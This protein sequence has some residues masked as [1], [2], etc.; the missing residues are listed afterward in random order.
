[1]ATN[2]PNTTEKLYK[3]YQQFLVITTDSRQISLRS[4]FFALK[5]ENFDGNRFAAQALEEGAAI[6]VVDDP[7]IVK[8]RRYILVDDVLQSLQQ[9]ASHHRQQ[10]NIPV[11]GITGSNGKTTTKELVHAV[12]STQYRTV[13][14]SGN[15]NNHIGVPLTLLSINLETEIAVIE[16]GANHP[17]EIAFLCEM[18]RPTHGLITNIGKAHLEGFGGFEGVVRAKTELFEFLKTHNGEVFINSAD[19]LLM[20]Y[21]AGLPAITY[22]LIPDAGTSCKIVSGKILPDSGKLAVEITF[23]DDQ[24]QLVRSGLFGSYNSLNLQAAACVGFRFAVPVSEISKAIERYAPANN[25]SQLHQTSRNLLVIDA[26]N[27]NPSSMTTALKDFDNAFQ[28]EKI[29]ILGDMLEL[30]SEAEKEHLGI[31]EMLENLNIQRIFLVGPVF[32]KLNINQEWTSFEDSQKAIEW[33]TTNPIE[34]ANILLKG[35]RGIRLEEIVEWL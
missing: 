6:A 8:D 9:L 32:S 34:H 21:A 5:G 14:T 27:A 7:A 17:G 11:I 3:L 16:M 18:A 28:S 30:G 24:K 33:F 35:S 31:L 19:P 1:M 2:I 25:R 26:Y 20:Q 15:L 22:G 29:V 23:P 10:L 12:L 13:S 4:I